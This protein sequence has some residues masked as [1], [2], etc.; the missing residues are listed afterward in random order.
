MY[1]IGLAVR[2][3][4]HARQPSQKIG[5]TLATNTSTLVQRCFNMLVILL[6]IHPVIQAGHLVAIAV[7]HQGGPLAEFAQPPLAPLA[8]PRMVYVRVHIGVKPV[9]GWN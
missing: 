3:W 2:F 8:P 9:L 4:L 5:A 1:S 6:E 7:E